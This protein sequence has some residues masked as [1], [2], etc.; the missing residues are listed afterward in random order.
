MAQSLVGRKLGDR[1]EI[2]R[3][4]G[5]GGMAEVYEAYHP[6]LDRIV[7]AKLM[8]RHLSRDEQFQARFEREAQAIARLK[9]PHIIQVYDFDL[10]SELSQYFM[11][12]EYVDG[13]TLG[14]VMRQASAPVPLAETVR[15]IGDVARALGYAHQEGMQHRDIKPANIMLDKGER[16]VLTDFG[17]A[18]LLREGGSQLTASGAM[19]GTP[20]YMSPEQASGYPGDYRS[21]IYSLGIVFYQMATGKLPYEGDSPI[22][23]ILKHLKEVPPAPTA[24]NPALPVGIES[25]ILRCMAKDPDDRYHSMDDLLAHLE[26]L[27]A[28]AAVVGRSRTLIA[29]IPSEDVFQTGI[30]STPTPADFRTAS[31]L[32]ATGTHFTD[33][34]ATAP[35]RTS[36]LIGAG[37]VAIIALLAL[38]AFLFS[39]A[40]S[41][42]TPA[43]EQTNACVVRL[44]DEIFARAEPNA[45]QVANI[46]FGDGEAVEVVG[47]TSGYWLI[48]SDTS[49]GWVASDVLDVP[50]SCD[51]E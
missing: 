21:D 44:E 11:I 5:E 45:Q 30:D 35:S 13:P 37:A 15:I 32:T 50:D 23:T 26:N 34:L 39:T 42:D 3:L 6:K 41:N 19:V 18:K 47:E 22:S 27:D 12:I 33:T 48:Q 29:K 46:A 24:V 28:A 38:G 51:V 7:A 43:I 1:Y 25:I 9:H 16:T 36:L 40:G 4:I 49:Q 10:D 31:P 17:I 20:A 2:R 8:H 14:G